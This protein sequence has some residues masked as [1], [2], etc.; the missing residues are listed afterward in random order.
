VPIFRRYDR[1]GL[2][3][4]VAEADIV[5]GSATVIARAIRLGMM[6]AEVSTSLADQLA[7]LSKLH[8][9]GNITDDEFASAKTRLLLRG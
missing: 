7:V 3:G 5:A 2:L 6:Q 1:P 8:S 9:A 4:A